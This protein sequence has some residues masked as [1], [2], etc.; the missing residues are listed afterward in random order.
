MRG[1]SGRSMALGVLI[2][3]L[4][5]VVVACGMDEVTGPVAGEVR[6]SPATADLEVST[7]QVPF[8]ARDPV[9]R[10]LRLRV[11]LALSPEQVTELLEIRTRFL[12]ANRESLEQ[13]RSAPPRARVSTPFPL[14]E[15]VRRQFPQAEDRLRSMN[16]E[17]RETARQRIRERMQ[18]VRREMAERRERQRERLT[19]LAPVRQE[20]RNVY[21]ALRDE[22]RSVLTP[23]QLQG[24]DALLDRAN[25]GSAGSPSG[26]AR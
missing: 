16:P 18:D 22:A 6:E 7:L 23:E 25:P 2:L 4:G 13:L 24:L 11:E 1:D 15:R 14:R 21:A 8:G 26:P 20:L 17:D 9:A 10:I 3:A 12:E 5:G 19:A